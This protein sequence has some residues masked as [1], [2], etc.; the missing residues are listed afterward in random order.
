[1]TVVADIRQFTRPAI[2]QVETR[3]DHEYGVYWGFMNPRSR[4]CF[5]KQ[6]LLDLHEFVNGIT[7]NH[8]MTWFAGKQHRI[9]YAVVAS[10]YPGVFNLG[11]DLD[12]FRDAIK[13][14]DRNQ[15]LSYGTQCVD[16]LYPWHRNCDL[17]LTTIALVQGDALG[18]GFEC[19]LASTVLIAEESARMGFPEILFNLF[20]GMGAYS[21]LSRKVGRR[22]T[23][24]LITSGAI[25]SAREMYD[26]G[27]VDMITADGTGEA[28]VL[29]FVRKHAKAANARRAIEQVRSELYPITRE[30]LMRVVELW[31]DAALRLDARD[32]RLMDRL[33]RA[34]ERATGLQ[35]SEFASNVRPIALATRGD[36]QLPRLQ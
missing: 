35:Q 6:L 30:E 14:G 19:A 11:G 10:K 22:K 25:Y 27:I 7:E 23:E 36:G 13:Q 1:M 29:S 2:S 24:E 28:A 17:P 3:F 34:Q 4:P 21:Y 8:G 9:R 5:T 33:V 15:L 31:V 18:G 12:A 20:P 16:N 26:L 32:L